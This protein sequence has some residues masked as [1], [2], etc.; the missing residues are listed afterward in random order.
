[1]HDLE[2][3][4][5]DFQRSQKRDQRELK[6]SAVR[7]PDWTE[8][9]PT[10]EVTTERVPE[11]FVEVPK[12]AAPK[13]GFTLWPT[14]ERKKVCR[15]TNLTQA[16][17]RYRTESTPETDRFD[18]EPRVIG[19]VVHFWDPKARCWAKPA[20]PAPSF[21]GPAFRRLPPCPEGAG[22]KVFVIY[23]R[24]RGAWVAKCRADTY[25]A[26]QSHAAAWAVSC[27]FR[28]DDVYAREV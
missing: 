18:P 10:W 25:A 17:G 7:A 16:D 4:R 3:D 1:M 9:N 15:P 13:I 6:L 26:A 11:T 5:R 23:E 8:D 20:K 28:G 2:R 14:F 22:S 19:G 12:Q 24:S 27:G 21:S